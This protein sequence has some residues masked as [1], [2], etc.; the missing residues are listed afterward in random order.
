MKG[1]LILNFR[2]LILFVVADWKSS[3][4]KTNQKS[5]IKNQK[6]ELEWSL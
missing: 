5:A 2:F 4:R 1:F 6:V 3:Q